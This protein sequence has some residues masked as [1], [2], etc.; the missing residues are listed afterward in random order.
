MHFVRVDNG[1]TFPF[2]RILDPGLSG[3]SGLAATAKGQIACLYEVFDPSLGGNLMRLAL[4][5][6]IELIGAL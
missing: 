5:E 4:V 3:Y 1:E 6:P 2:S